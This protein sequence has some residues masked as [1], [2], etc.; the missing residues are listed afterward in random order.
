[1]NRKTGL[2]RDNRF[3]LHVNGWNH[4]ESPARLKTIYKMLDAPDMAGHFVDIP[5][6]DATPEDLVRI[7]RPLY[8]EQ[9]AATRGQPTVS[10][11]PDTDAMEDTYDVAVLAAGSICRAIDYVMDGRVDNAF[12]LVRPPGHH[13]E[14]YTAAGF[15]I[16]NNV[17]IGARYALAKGLAKKILIVDWDVHHGNGTQHSFYDDNQVLYFSTH[18][19]HFYP[20]TGHVHETGQGAGAGYT[21]NCPLTYGADDGFFLR[22]F[23]KLLVPVTRQYKPDL[24]LVSAGFDTHEDD[25]L[26]SMRMTARGYAALTRI[27]M[28]EAD[29]ACGGKIVFTLEGGYSLNALAVSIKAILKELRDETCLT[30]EELDE[31]EQSTHV[32]S[33]AELDRVIE[34]LQPFWSGL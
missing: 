6:K 14:A 3:L 7:H 9:I 1:M 31:M 2:I 17:A 32:R 21:I 5:P 19:A 30:T 4:P 29:A 22:I 24:I 20:G 18:Q 16:F 23:R 12:A 25:P 26:G 27:L 13:A 8:V 28:N 10:L 11:D 33:N 34:Q 15:C